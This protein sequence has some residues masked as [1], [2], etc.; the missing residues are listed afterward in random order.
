MGVSG[1]SGSDLPLSIAREDLLERCSELLGEGLIALESL[2]GHDKIGPMIDAI[3]GTDEPEIPDPRLSRVRLN[4]MGKIALDTRSALTDIKPSWEYRANNKRFEK[5]AITFSRLAT[6]WY[7][8]RQIDARFVD[9]MDYAMVAGR[10]WLHHFWNPDIQDIDVRAEDPRDVIPIRQWDRTTVQNAKGVM[11]RRE[12]TVGY[13]RRTYNRDDLVPD[14]NGSNKVTAVARKVAEIAE[15]IV[16]D[17]GPFHDLL[18]GG[19]KPAS[20]LPGSPPVID[21]IIFYCH[22]HTVNTK[23]YAVEIGEFVDETLPSGRTIRAPKYSWCYTVDPGEPLYPRGRRIV[24]CRQDILEDGPNHFMHG[25]FPLSKIPIDSFAFGDKSPLWDLHQLQRAL[26]EVVR[27]IQDKIR[28]IGRPGLRYDKNSIARAVARKIDMRRDGVKIAHNPTAG[29]PPEPIYE[30][31]NDLQVLI[32]YKRE[33]ANDMD[34]LSGITDLKALMRLGQL[35]SSETIDKITEAM[36][37]AIRQRSRALE[38]MIREFAMMMAANFMQFYTLAL[39]LRI[40]GPDG[41]T[42]E[43]WDYDPRTMVPDFIHDADYN[44]D[45]T[46]RQ[47]AMTRGPRALHTRV[48]DFLRYFTY[49]VTPGSLLDA[50]SITKKLL[51]LQLSRMGLIDHWTLL[52]QFEIANVGAAPSNAPTITDRLIAEAR[53]GLGVIASTAGRPPSAQAMPAMAMGGNGMPTITES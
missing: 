17:R 12:R 29:K 10:G 15:T 14:R 16:G 34:E 32:E 24:F 42:M 6:D 27:V 43:D 13:M 47:E 37:P 38:I 11:V 26:D 35:P 33:I 28:R 19:G 36:T 30:P 48:P 3:M 8:R 51:Y 52:E 18:F 20:K 53:M 22:D 1:V 23:T 40:L 9:G 21:E 4:K 45:G 25:M 39:R 7:T 46:V 2:P 49:H 41:I 50:A 44:P 31:I 5:N